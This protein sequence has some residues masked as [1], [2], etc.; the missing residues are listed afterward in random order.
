MRARIFLRQ[1]LLGPMSFAMEPLVD[2]VFEDPRWEEFGLQMLADRAAR[3]TFAGLGFGAKDAE[4]EGH[5]ISCLACDDARIAVLNEDFRGKPTPTNVLSWPSDELA[6][7]EDGDL[8]D[9]PDLDGPF[10]EG[11]GDIAIA[12]ET[13]AREAVDQGKSMADHVTHLI[14]HATLHLLGYDHIR[15][16]DAQ[17]MENTEIRILATMGLANPYE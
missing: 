17:L 12:W 6:A 11:L 5:E 10:A 1:G 9:A 4:F 14:I 7:E 3:A 8:P 15:E 2:I 16:G 13:C